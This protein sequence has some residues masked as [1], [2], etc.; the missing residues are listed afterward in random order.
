[1]EQEESEDESIVS[2]ERKLLKATSDDSIFGKSPAKIKFRRESAYVV[3]HFLPAC[4][5]ESFEYVH[6]NSF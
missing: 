6:E 4:A 2:V 3:E 5:R 1:M